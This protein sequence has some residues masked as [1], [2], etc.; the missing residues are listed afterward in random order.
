VFITEI[1][2]DERVGDNRL[3]L[4]HSFQWLGFL[5]PPPCKKQNNKQTLSNET[6]SSW[7]LI[8]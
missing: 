2:I 1:F 3:Q 7:Y 8:F 5:S 6:Q 4:N